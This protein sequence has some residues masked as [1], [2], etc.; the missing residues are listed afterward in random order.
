MSSNRRRVELLILDMDNTLYD[1][2][3]YFVPA[4]DAMTYE[5]AR[6]LGVPEA[7]LRRDLRDVHRLWGTTDMPFALLESAIVRESFAGLTRDETYE[8]LLPAFLAFDSEKRAILSLYEG[9]SATLADVKAS[10]CQ[11]VGHTEAAVRSIRSRARM[12]RLDRFVSTIY[13]TASRGAGHPKSTNRAEIS[14]RIRYRDY[15]EIAVISVSEAERKPNPA[16]I[17]HILSDYSVAPNLCLYVGDSLSR[18]IAMALRAGVMAAWARYGT[19]HDSEQYSRLLEITH[20][21]AQDTSGREMA[22]DPSQFVT[23]TRFSDLL[24][25]YEFGTSS[26]PSSDNRPPLTH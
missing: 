8:R 1:W 6:I 16:L 22:P 18:D 23:L 3:G 17:R 9:V 24:E 5:A 26:A 14:A 4:F 21:G 15:E 25:R 19:W 20:W 12:L 10:G 2:V 13:A 11:I 7:D